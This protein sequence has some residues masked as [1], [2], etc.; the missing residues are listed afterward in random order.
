M[1]GIL[2]IWNLDGRP[3]EAGMLSRLSATLAHRGPD[4]EGQ[5]L[6]GP[7]GL[8]CQLMRVTPES[9]HETQPLVHL[10]GAVIVFDGRLDN[11]E[12]L[13]GL[14]K[15]AWG[16]ETDSPDPALVLAAYVA[17]GE[18]F[19]ERL[20]GDF[21]LAIY[22]P[23]RR[24]LL[25]ARDAVGPRPL[26]YY[27][28]GNTFLFASE[29]KAI[30]AHPE[31]SAK[32]NDDV[33]AEFL[34]GG[35]AP[36]DPGATFFAG[37]YSLP[38]G[39]LGVIT[40]SGF[41]SRRY[42][43]FD[44]LKESRYRS[45]PDYAEALKGHFEESV[46]RRLRSAHPVAVSVSGGLDSS[47]IFCMAETLRRQYPGR[48]PEL[49]GISY[50]SP[51]GTPS[52]EKD[53]LQE[54]ERL[55]GVSMTKLPRDGGTRFMD[56]YPALIRQV[57][58]PIMD[59]Q[60][61]EDERFNL[62]ARGLGARL[63]LTGHWGDET[64]FNR[65]YLSD[66]CHRGQWRKVW[67]HLEEFPRWH[68]KNLDDPN[69]FKRFFFHDLVRY[70]LPQAVIPLLRRWRARR[71][72]PYF[73]RPW[74]T[75]TFRERSL[76]PG[77]RNGHAG[78][79]F[80][81]AYCNGLYYMVRSRLTRFRLERHNKVAARQGLEVTFP[82]LD[83]DLVAFLMG[84]PGE[85]LCWQGVPRNLM[86]RAMQGILPA[87]IAGRRWKAD[88]SHLINEGMGQDYPLVEQYLQSGMAAA[89]YGYIEA[90]QVA[91]ELSRLKHRI[92][93]NNRSCLA[94]WSIGDLLSLET[95]LRDYF[96]TPPKEKEKI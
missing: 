74:Y 19:A 31:V 55:Y 21:A 67:E 77:K 93:N 16:A 87:A 40:P 3:V 34:L 6:E 9:L 54:I 83:R 58:T 78:K 68:I 53:F 59:L 10:S 70:H 11:R 57:E 84:C 51:D 61:Q 41:S 5:W 35:P 73:D 94:A 72:P 85:F 30:L 91:G 26:Y 43:D 14:L 50:I 90:G 17:F 82:F 48:Y 81:T 80:K 4:G 69:T 95:W 1:S 32:P 92:D 96:A 18:G 7:V 38:P 89:E 13:L 37:I 39:F 52:D 64:H 2:G 65:A 76:R 12:E 88:F 20:N 79:K 86:R 66:L 47:S 62:T 25:L 44:N 36:E 27:R 45:F 63:K 22:D 75:G 46:R 23:P 60:W 29:I 15:G 24:R 33:L 71:A 49:L 56:G 28:T 42:W 8:A